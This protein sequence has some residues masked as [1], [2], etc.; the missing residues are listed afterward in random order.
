MNVW[1]GQ[2]WRETWGPWWNRAGAPNSAQSCRE[3][4]LGSFQEEIY[5]KWEL[6]DEPG[7]SSGQGEGEN[8]ECE[9]LLVTDRGREAFCGAG[10]WTARVAE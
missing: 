4:K 8:R 1:G 6:R 3:G 5:L 2:L 9:G 7:E 10:C